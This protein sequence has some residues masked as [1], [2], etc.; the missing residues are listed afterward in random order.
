MAPFTFN[1]LCI[2]IG[3]SK[4]DTHQVGQ[5][6]LA[7]GLN[8]SILTEQVVVFTDVLLTFDIKIHFIILQRWLSKHVRSCVWVG[9]IF[10]FSLLK[11]Q[12]VHWLSVP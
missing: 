1:L 3:T 9:A 10:H 12:P 5:N 6:S 4:Q 2:S 7:L 8:L 11:Q